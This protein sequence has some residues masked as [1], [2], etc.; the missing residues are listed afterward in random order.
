ML[1]RVAQTNLNFLTK[2]RL[3]SIQKTKGITYSVRFILY[4][5][6]DVVSIAQIVFTVVLLMLVAF[7]RRFP[8]GW[9]FTSNVNRLSTF[10]AVMLSSL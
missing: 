8:K 2:S 7:V 9:P 4:W 3:Q 6:W 10:L 1:V 5:M